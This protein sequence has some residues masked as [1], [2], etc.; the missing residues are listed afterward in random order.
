MKILIT[1][2]AGFIGSAVIRKA[3]HDGHII[4]NIDALTYASSLDSLLSVAE[5][6]NYYFE[7]IDLR[8]RK[9]IDQVLEKFQPDSII[10]LAAE[11]HV[12][13]SIDDASNFITTNING[14]FNLLESSRNYWES[15]GKPKDFR[16]IHIST[17]EVFGSLEYESDIQFE[18]DSNYDPNSPYAS[19]KAAADHL[20]QAWNKTYGLP[21]IITH[22]SNNY[23]P[24]QFPEK[25]IPVVIINALN[26]KSIPI[27]GDGK[28]IRD[29][30]HVDDHAEAL[31]L[32]LE[33]GKNG[34]NYNI[35]GRTEITNL[36]I[37]NQICD[38]VDCIKK[39]HEG[40]SAK[41]ITFVEDR[42]AHDR[43]Y[44]INTDKLY[45]HL[46]WSPRIAFERGLEQTVHWYFE[47]QDWWRPLLSRSG[48]GDRLGKL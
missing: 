12:D 20:V 28:N 36:A 3:I 44:A 2:G 13:R 21:V 1:G 30:I 39:V 34:D 23:G 10:H 5:S 18:E 4:C 26:N 25:L 29:W 37:T 46:N 15:C 42:P 43:R 16:F 27:Y 38:I 22:S 48:V 17:D 7:H 9:K 14:T 45:S 11:S 47:N 33:K 40:S 35:G 19:S 8:E 41:L 24:Y 32:L 31:L 6:N